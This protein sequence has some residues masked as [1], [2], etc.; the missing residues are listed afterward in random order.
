LLGPILLRYQVSR[1]TGTLGTLLANGIGLIQAIGISRE[2]L[3]YSTLRQRLA[4]LSDAI[5]QGQRFSRI[6]ADTRLLDPA[7]LQ[8]VALGEETGRLDTML[9][10][11]TKQQEAAL[12]TQTRRLLTL[13]EPLLILS[14]GLVIALIIIAILLGILSVNELVA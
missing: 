14:L 2:G 8:L 10:E 11:L 9:L 7:A 12:Q 5:K 3:S 4:P 1:F 13:L 6:I